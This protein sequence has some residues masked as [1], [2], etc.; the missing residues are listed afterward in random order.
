MT[1]TA[2]STPEK[3]GAA[4]FDELSEHAPECA[5]RIIFLTG[6]AFTTEGRSF[7]ERVPNPRLEKPFEVRALRTLVNE[8]LA[9]TP[10]A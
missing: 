8:H 10:P 2:G 4:F 6:G 3:S 7:L 9:L 5:R 1:T